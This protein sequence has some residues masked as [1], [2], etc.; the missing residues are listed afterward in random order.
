MPHCV[1]KTL[2]A[3]VL[4]QL[5]M[6]SRMTYDDAQGAS[7]EA[8]EQ[9]ASALLV[10]RQGQSDFQHQKRMKPSLGNNRVLL[11]IT[12]HVSPVHVEFLQKCWPALISN[13]ALLQQADV[14]L[15]TGAELPSDIVQTVFHDNH[16]RVER[17]DNPGYQ[18]GAMLAM[19]T[20]TERRWFDGYDWVIRVNPDVLI[21]DDD[22]L[23]KKM[24]DDGVDGIFA[25]CHDANCTS[26]CTDNFVNSDFFAVRTTHLGQA[27][28]FELPQR[29]HAFQME[30][31]E[32]QV[33][34]AFKSIFETGR[35]R[36]IPGTNM[37]GMCRVHGPAVPVLHSHTVLSQCPLAKGQP[38]NRD[39]E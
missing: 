35:D 37:H 20:A 19:E 33:G 8:N 12:T 17:Y 25:D 29:F 6:A 34:A 16:V 30:N 4:L 2:T 11:F 10:V 23:I 21:L 31:A 39:I 22:W 28:F 27:S 14:L 38:E 3:L 24:A 15:F 13:S 7:T 1:V 36:W 9:K 32:R 18:S 5:T 26:H